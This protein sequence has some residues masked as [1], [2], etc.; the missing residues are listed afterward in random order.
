MS[1]DNASAIAIST[2][3]TRMARVRALFSPSE[4][5]RLTGLYGFIA[6][7]HIVGWG[8]FITYSTSYPTLAGLGVVAYLFGLRHAFDA[9]HIS[10]V[11]DTIRF[12]LQKGKQ[13]H[14]NIFCVS[15]LIILIV[16]SYGTQ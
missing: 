1:D 5:A 14:D 3:Q 8:L 6:F 9:D 4:W 2:P 10:A 11:D 13:P 16:I 12:M 7:L 15:N